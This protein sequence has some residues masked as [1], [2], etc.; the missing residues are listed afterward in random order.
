VPARG[1][2]HVDHLAAA[3][4][5]YYPPTARTAVGYAVQCPKCG[6]EPDAPCLTAAGKKGPVHAARRDLAVK[7]DRG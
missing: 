6:A 5:I 1:W 4:R 7:R 2:A 3:M